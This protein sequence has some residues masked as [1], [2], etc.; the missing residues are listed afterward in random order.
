MKPPFISRRGVVASEH[1]YAS[2]AALG[3]LEEGGN[4]V[5]AAVAISFTLAVSQPALNGLGGD[6][7]ATV[8][9]GG[10]TTFVNGS[11]WAPRRLTV[12]MVRGELGLGSIPR[13][14]PLSAVV[15]GMVDGVHAMWRKFGSMEWGGLL[16][17]AIRRAREGLPASPALR[18]AVESIDGSYSDANT[19]RIY[20]AGRWERVDLSGLAATIEGIAEHGPEFF[21]RDVGAAIA[22]YVSSLGG[23]MEPDDFSEYRAEVSGTVSCTYR[24]YTVHE[25]PPNSQG[26][27]TLLILRELEE[28]GRGRG[29]AV[30]PREMLEAYARAYSLRDR[31]VADPRFVEVPVEELLS[32]G[33]EGGSTARSTGGGDTTNF[34]VADSGGM[35]VSGIQ[36]LYHG[37]GS[38]VTEP[39]HQVTLNNRASDFSMEGP[40]RVEPRKRPLHTLSSV[41]VTRDGEPFVALGT[42]GGHFRPQQH[43]LLI[44]NMVDRGMDVVEAVDSPRFLW[45]GSSVIAEEGADT[46]GIDARRIPYPGSTGVA[47]AIQFRGADRI[48]HADPRGEGLALGELD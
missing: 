16:S 43:A 26:I 12:E 4:A 7:M 28:R 35:V 19:K 29:G 42:S 31:Y 32:G 13:Y 41:I 48:A 45:D 33:V 39:S 15:P 20:S 36:S 27:T 21:Y 23:V 18:A 38:R 1:P 24:G 47:H 34:V 14:G 3:V 37:F 2:M 25:S 30:G 5:D 40:N 10:R 22:D 6:F 44:V 17:S 8:L 9:R 46:G 11:G